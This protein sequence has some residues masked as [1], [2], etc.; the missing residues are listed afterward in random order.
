MEE[1]MLPLVEINQIIE[2][3]GPKYN[4]NFM[5]FIQ[6]VQFRYLENIGHLLSTTQKQN[7]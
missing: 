1:S 4:Q 5:I 3:Q 2:N 7:G 6:Y